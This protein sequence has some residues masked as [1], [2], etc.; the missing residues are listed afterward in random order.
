MNLST[1]LFRLGITPNYKAY[2]QLITAITLSSENT[3]LLMLVTKQ[4][5]PAVAQTYHTSWRAVERN[6]RLASDRA[7]QCNPALL[8]ELA[9]HPLADTPTSSQLIAIL[10]GWYEK[11]GAGEESGR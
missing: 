5:Y 1:L 4:L 7:W 8:A 9:G 6:I 11:E 2:H 3:G 10:A